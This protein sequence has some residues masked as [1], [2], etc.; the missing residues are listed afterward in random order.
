MSEV[1]SGSLSFKTPLMFT[2]GTKI[3][4]K[5]TQEYITH[6]KG[7]FILAPSGA[8]KTYF[9]KNQKKKDWLDGDVIWEASNAHPK[10]AWWLESLEVTDEI[11]QRSDVIT[12][13]AKRLGFWIMGASN[14]W[15][16]PDAIVLP[17]WSTHKKYIRIRE[18]TN[19]DGGATSDRLSQV[20]KH[21]KWIHGWTKKGVP[22]FK[23]IDEA[24]DYLVISSKR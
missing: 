15:L 4:Q 24:V 14:F 18:Q 12:T 9:I 11:D 8:G 2:D 5:L 19:Y 20:L 3:Y 10:G 13:Q 17:N 1:H 16:K 23:S 21:R 22:A 7:L 6:K